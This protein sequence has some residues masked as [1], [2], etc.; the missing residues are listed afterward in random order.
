MKLNDIILKL[1]H[2]YPFHNPQY[3]TTDDEVLILATM[4]MS[5]WPLSGQSI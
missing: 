2:G 3:N 1:L 5:S 4:T